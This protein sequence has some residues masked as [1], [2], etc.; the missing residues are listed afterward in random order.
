MSSRPSSSRNQHKPQRPCSA[1]SAV[2]RRASKPYSARRVKPQSEPIEEAIDFSAHP[3]D[4]RKMPSC[5]NKDPEALYEEN[6]GLRHLK[7]ELHHELSSWKTRAI[8]SEQGLSKTKKQLNDLI[9]AKTIADA[10]VLGLD[11]LRHDT[12]F[13]DR[14]REENARLSAEVRAKDLEM[15]KLKKD[16]RPTRVQELESQLSQFVLEIQ[17]LRSV[18][19]EYGIDADSG[20][21]LEKKD[22]TKVYIQ[23]LKST[24]SSLDSQVVSLQDEL[25]ALKVRNASE[26]A[27][28]EALKHSNSE[29][30]R[31]IFELEKN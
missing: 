2:L 8:R 30:T 22:P 13:N 12:S 28:V 20:R 3:L 11:C 7:N 16:S 25:S 26:L 29:L 10:T 1:S 31:H 24:I 21:R 4:Q 18:L 14:L 19:V 9:K 5:F 27:D 17:R 15:V 6:L 23:E